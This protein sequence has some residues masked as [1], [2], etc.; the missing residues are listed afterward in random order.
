[1]KIRAK[2][3]F[4]NLKEIFQKGD[5]LTLNVERCQEDTIICNALYG[6][7]WNGKVILRPSHKIIDHNKLPEGV[8]KFCDPVIAKKDSYK[9]STITTADGRTYSTSIISSMIGY[10]QKMSDI[11]E[12]L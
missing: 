4:E 7:L 2:K 9:S 11:F 10:S 8:W 12:K 5:V 3:T 1:M 6:Q